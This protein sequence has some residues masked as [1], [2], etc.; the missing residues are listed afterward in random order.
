MW[1]EKAK[2]WRYAL[3]Q[4]RAQRSS[5]Q[6]IALADEVHCG[7]SF[8]VAVTRVT[9]CVHDLF[10]HWNRI[11]TLHLVA[12]ACFTHVIMPIKIDIPFL[13]ILP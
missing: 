8:D 3:L 4:L 9:C 2:E 10:Q 12:P 6:K 11:S 5:L 13:V 7:R 1:A